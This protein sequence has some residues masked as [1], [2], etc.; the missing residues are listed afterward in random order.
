[1]AD[2]SKFAKSRTMYVIPVEY[3]RAI[4][5]SQREK[6]DLLSSPQIKL[7]LELDRK[8]RDLLF[9]RPDLDKDEKQALYSSLLKQFIWLQEKR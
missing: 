1:M 6:E 8:M 2:Q 3:M 4:L 5:R 7:L 9:N